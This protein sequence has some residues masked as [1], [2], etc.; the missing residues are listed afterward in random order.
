M[1]FLPATPAGGGKWN[2]A[3]QTFDGPTTDKPNA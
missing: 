3:G 2:V 1:N